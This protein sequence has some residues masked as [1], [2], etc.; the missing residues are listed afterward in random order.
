LSAHAASV[1]ITLAPVF[2][3]T[4][5]VCLRALWIVTAGFVVGYAFTFDQE[6]VRHV[7]MALSLHESAGQLRIGWSP[8]AAARGAKLE[9][10]DGALRTTLFVTAPLADVT[11]AART[12][13]VQVRL[14]SAGAD[15]Q[16]AI[17][18]FVVREVS[19]AELTAQFGAVLAEAQALQR[20]IWRSNRQL[21]DLEAAAQELTRPKQTRPAVRDKKL[22]RRDK[23]PL[24][25]RWWR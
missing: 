7:P 17:A 13:D 24:Q 19:A 18:R 11:Y 8:T 25:T 15:G 12:A 23:K 14:T 6:Q 22:R 5:Q 1:E 3:P 16:T 10:L 20:A 21:T 4:R 2:R 9:I